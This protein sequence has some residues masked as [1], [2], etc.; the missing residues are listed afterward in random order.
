MGVDAVVEVSSIPSRLL[1]FVGVYYMSPACT[2]W[3]LVPIVM[4][5]LPVIMDK[6]DET[7]VVISNNIGLFFVA[8]GLGLFLNMVSYHLIQLTSSVFMK[9]LVV[10]RTA[11]FVIFC[12]IFLGEA[13]S[14]VEFVGYAFSLV[15]FSYYSFYV[16]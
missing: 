2:V 9:V 4:Y 15:C 13:I 7:S 1:F 5:E 11:M 16:K 6:W 3:L 14:F 8:S 10:A 12:F